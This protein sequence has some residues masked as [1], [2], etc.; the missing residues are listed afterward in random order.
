MA[1][2]LGEEGFA[3]CGCDGLVVLWKVIDTFLSVDM[4]KTE[5]LTCLVAQI[6]YIKER[7]LVHSLPT[8]SMLVMCQ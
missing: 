6:R 1:V 2:D 4:S 3:S 8:S 5:P 7:N